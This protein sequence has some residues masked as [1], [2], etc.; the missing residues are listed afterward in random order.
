MIW[1]KWGIS[2]GKA[3]MCIAVAFFIAAVLMIPAGVVLMALNG[4]DLNGIME[5]A[6]ELNATNIVFGIVQAVAFITAV[7]LMYTAFERK[8]GW[9]LGWK[10]KKLASN[11]IVGSSAGIIL[12]T[13]SFLLIWVYRGIAVTESVPITSFLNHFLGCMLLFLFVA[14]SE[15]LFSRGYVYGLLKQQ[16]SAR[17]A[18]IGSALVFTILHSL[19]PGMFE[20]P[21]P[22]INLFLVG[23]LFALCREFTGGLWVPI[24]L[25]FTW[26]LFQGNIYGFAVSGTTGQSMMILDVQEGLLAGGTFGAEGSFMTTVVLAAAAAVVWIAGTS[27][28]TPQTLP[29][30]A[31]SD[32]IDQ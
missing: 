9:P 30:S 6:D 15:E 7:I 25:H 23:I 18:A 3:A 26:N 32:R 21:F 16:F 8:K 10:E 11:F 4:G 1:T 20:Q 31:S 24:G 12:I 28:R 14:V 22:V 13:C 29:I 19:N 27:A 2:L 17:A 5:E